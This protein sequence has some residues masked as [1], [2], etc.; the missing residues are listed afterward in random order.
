MSRIWERLA[1]EGGSIMIEVLVGTVLLALTTA[2]VLDGLDGAQKTGRMN[3][4]RSTAATLAQQDLERLRSLP[5]TLL[6]N[7]TQTRAVTLG[8]VTYTVVSRAEA[9][10][11]ASGLVSC[12]TDETDSEYLRL[13]S[14][15]HAPASVDRPVTATSLLTPPVG[16]LGDDTGTV[17]VK[18]TDRDGEP[19]PGVTVD[20][21]GA[22]SYSN[23]TNDVGCAVFAFVEAGNWTAEV[24]GDLV[25]WNGDT[26]ATSQVA[27][28]AGKTSLT[29]IELDDPASLRATFVTPSGAPTQWRSI[30]VTNAKLPNGYKP[31]AVG[32]AS[33]SKDAEGLFPFRDGYG[34]FAGDCEANNPALWDSDYFETSGYGFVALDPGDLLEP[35]Q[36]VVPQLTLKLKRTGST[37]DAIQVYVRQV[38][39]AYDCDSVIYNSGLIPLSPAVAEATL[40]IPLPFGRYQVCGA[41]RTSSS[42]RSRLTATSGTYQHPNL[43]T[44]TAATLSLDTNG[45]TSGNSCTQVPS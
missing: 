4:D 16:A 29:Q 34:V 27:V 1:G 10:R 23:T 13:S 2:A 37:S 22:T 14:T 15:V 26:P 31:F 41:T 36:V 38:D 40:T 45:A 33:A 24:D 39:T 6:V 30:S 21:Q 43:R 19:L 17:A 7:L 8:P 18:L 35:V 11:D 12:T 3:K 5:P 42:W 28:A 20:L 44:A 32:A 25:T 9:V